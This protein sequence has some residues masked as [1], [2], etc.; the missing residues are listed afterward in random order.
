[1][2]IEFTVI[3]DFEVYENFI[4]FSLF[5]SKQYR[6]AKTTFFLPFILIIPLAVLLLLMGFPPLLPIAALSL[7]L[8]TFLVFGFLFFILPKIQYKKL[9]V[10]FTAPQAFSLYE[11]YFEVRQEADTASGFSKINYSELTKVYETHNGFYLFI[12]TNQAFPIPKKAL[13]VEQC[14]AI[15]NLLKTNLEPKK[16]KSCY[17]K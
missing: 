3:K 10:L 4:I 17:K 11:T 6:T 1:M 2:P 13:T 8:F 7:S 14:S 12:S 9:S 5:K 15:E 16:Y